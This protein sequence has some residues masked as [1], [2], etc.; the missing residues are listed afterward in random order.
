MKFKIN[1]RIIQEGG[2]DYFDDVPS[3]HNITAVN[4]LHGLC[5]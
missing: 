2:N 3:E 4:P 1:N 5:G